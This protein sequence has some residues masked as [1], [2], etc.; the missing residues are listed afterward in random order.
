MSKDIVLVTY[1]DG[2]GDYFEYDIDD[3]TKQEK[4]DTRKKISKEEAALKLGL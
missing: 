3:D 2:K 4:K 1:L